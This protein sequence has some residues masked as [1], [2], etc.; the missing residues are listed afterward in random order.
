MNKRIGLLLLVLGLSGLSSMTEAS[1][2]QYNL[3]GNIP[4]SREVYDP[5]NGTSLEFI[6]LA[7]NGTCLISDEDL[8]PDDQYHDHFNIMGYNVNID[9]YNFIDNDNPGVIR[10]GTLDVYIS[11]AGGTFTE[12][13]GPP[14]ELPSSFTVFSSIKRPTDWYSQIYAYSDYNFHTMSLRFERAPEPV[15]EPSTLMLLGSV[16]PALAVLR[17]RFHKNS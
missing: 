7:L 2:V 1:I 8:L 11:L 16:I 4:L 10:F 13:Y 17:R 14:H 3:T 5:D 9:E 12:C 15:P 6:S